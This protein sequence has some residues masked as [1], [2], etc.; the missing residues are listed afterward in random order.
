MAYIDKKGGIRELTLKQRKFLEQYLIHGNAT[1]AY[2]AAYNCENQG[3]ATVSQSAYLLTQHPEISLKI[4]EAR[5][6]AR[7]KHAITVDDLVA[8]L[9]EARA[10]SKEDRVGGTMVAATMGKGKLL[11]LIV[12][13]KEL[14]VHGMISSMNDDELSRFILEVDVDS[15]DYTDNS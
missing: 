3:D 5:E 4:K 1:K 14:T 7:Q 10:I 8:E 2:R 11:G 15:D 6:L 13:R 9:E 12:D